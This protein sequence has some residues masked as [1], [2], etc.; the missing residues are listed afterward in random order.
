MNSRTQI[1]K[2]ARQVLP[3]FVL[4]GLR[5]LKRSTDQPVLRYA[6]KGW[7]T[8]LSGGENGWDNERVVKVEAAKWNEFRRNLEGTGPLGFSHEHTDLTETRNVYFHNIHLTFAYVLSLAAQH[9]AEVSVLDWGGGLGHY[10]LLGKSLLP[11]LNL[12]FDC[13]DVPLMCARGEK[14]CPEVTFC[15]DDKCLDNRYDLVMVNGSIGYFKEWKDVLARLCD[16][17]D[18]YLFLTRVLT[19]P[20][21]PSFVVLQRTDVYGYNSDMLTQVLN[22]DEVLSVVRDRGLTLVREFVVGEGPTIVDAPEQCR[23]CGWLFER[24]QPATR[25]E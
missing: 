22:E 15:S 12:K 8:P 5:R 19:V 11:D 23:D 7:D 10:Y 18:R 1:G 6:P 24:A 14:L 4:G 16:A 3:P 9:K 20:H 25:D 17:A 21:S 2:L 13:R